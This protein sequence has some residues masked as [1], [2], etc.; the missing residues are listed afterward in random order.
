MRRLN[1]EQYIDAL[2]E[3]LRMRGVT[4]VCRG[5]AEYPE[6]LEE[7]ADIIIPPELLFVRGN[8]DLNVLEGIAVVGTRKCSPEVRASPGA[9]AETLRRRALSS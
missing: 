6:C 9:L 8:R 7:L 4:F 5:D 3:R 2:L 1:S